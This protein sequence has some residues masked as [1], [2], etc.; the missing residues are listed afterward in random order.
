MVRFKQLLSFPMFG[1]SV[2]LVWVV[3]LQ[4]GDVA[5]IA[6]LGGAVLIA[7]VIWLLQ[8]SAGARGFAR[9]A[10]TVAALI[11]VFT[12]GAMTQY[13]LQ[14]ADERSPGNTVA[15]GDVPLFT[16]ARLE[17]TR[18]SGKAVFVNYTAAWCVTCIVNEKAILG[19]SWFR[20]AMEKAGIVYMKGDWTKRDPAITRELRKFK[21]LGVPLYVFYPAA[22]SRL[23]PE[24][25]PQI[26]TESRVRAAIGKFA[27]TSRERASKR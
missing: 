7:F 5:L 23:K 15:E 27:T 24:V 16:P 21:R 9:G 25:L 18:A 1:T 19:A 8:A 6:A 10:V 20:P 3:T 12:I 11:A 17:A 22:G 13:A 4:A 26:L 2:W 14:Q